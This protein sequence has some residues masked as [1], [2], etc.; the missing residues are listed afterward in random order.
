MTPRKAL[1]EVQFGAFVR[2][3]S[4]TPGLAQSVEELQPET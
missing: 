2:L 3:D 4:V 1:S